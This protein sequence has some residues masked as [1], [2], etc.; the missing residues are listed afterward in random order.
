MSRLEK[1]SSNS[2]RKLSRRVLLLGA[3]Q[4]IIAG[5]I[6]R[7]IV[8]LQAIDQKYYTDQAEANRISYGLILPERG[9]I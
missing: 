5:V 6:G 3:A 2:A 7:R 4:L 9:L 1:M 8:Y